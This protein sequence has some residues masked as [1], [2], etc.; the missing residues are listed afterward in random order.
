M[1]EKSLE[2]I[3]TR[4][5]SDLYMAPYDILLSDTAQAIRDYYLEKVNE[6]ENPYPEDLFAI[7]PKEDY[8]KINELLIKEMGYPLDRLSGN[9][10]RQLL[11]GIKAEMRKAIEEG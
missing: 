2:D 8:K 1:P 11:M 4:F 3:L 9:I 7:I 5:T 6:I 10:G